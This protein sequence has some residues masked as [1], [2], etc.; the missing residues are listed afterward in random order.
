MMVKYDFDKLELPYT[1]I[2]LGEVQIAGIVSQEKL[3]A[4]KLALVEI[5]FDLIYDKKHSLLKK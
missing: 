4:L 2:E 1:L 3:Q 5:G